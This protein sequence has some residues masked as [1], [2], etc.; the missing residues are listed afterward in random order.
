MENPLLILLRMVDSNQPH[1]DKLRSMVLMVDDH[2][3]I[4]MSE[5]NYEDYLPPITELED[6]KNEEGPV[7]DGPPEYL[8]DDEDV[9]N[10]EDSISSQDKNGIGGKIL[11]L[12]ERYKP[13]LDNDCSRVGYIL[14]VDAK[15]YAP[16]KISVLYIYVNYH[17]ILLHLSIFKRI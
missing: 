4:S 16:A 9:S 3:R 7:D 1:M 12:W 5:L 10:T 15:T 11:A 8:S 6:D 2:M 17:V 13:L 14:F